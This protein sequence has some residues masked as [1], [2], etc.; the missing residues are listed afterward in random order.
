MQTRY[1]AAILAGLLLVGVLAFAAGRG[2]GHVAPRP[3]PVDPIPPRPDPGPS[4]P[5]VP[6]G[7]VV[8]ED[9]LKVDQSRG[10]FL[11]NKRVQA[12]FKATNLQH[13]VYSVGAVGPDGKPIGGRAGELIAA[14]KAKELPYLF[15]LDS[16]GAVIREQKLDLT[17]PDKFIDLFDPHAET[18][19]AMGCKNEPPLLS[20]T[21]F[22][23]AAAP[24][25]RLIPREQ[26]QPVDLEAY[27][28][29]VYD[30]DGRG[31]CNASAT[32]SALEFAREVGGM[33]YVHLSAGDLYSQINGGRDDGSTLE[34][35]LRAALTTGVAT[36]RTVPYVWNGRR[37]E[38]AAAK[39]ERQLYKA[40]E[41]YLCP[42]F[43]HVASAIQQGFIPIIGMKWHGNFKPD[44]DGWLPVRGSGGYGGHAI[45]VCGLDKRVI[46]GKEVWALKIRNSW[47]AAWGLGGNCY[48]PEPLLDGWIG[49]H[50]AVRSVVRTPDSFPA[51]K[52][53]RAVRLSLNPSELF[54]PDVAP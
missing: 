16:A 34:A 23:T 54:A 25:T 52:T 53:A 35:G 41:V 11:A 27:L 9:T 20:W 15:A 17:E 6:A 13:A 18:P 49:G 24:T 19:R 7:V 28:G 5:A 37:V 38:N 39:G 30:Q 47:S 12:F 46:G 2:C 45:A 48:V 29:P 43:D 31:Q 14:A 32:C 4:P 26:W 42:S 3:D 40:A 50:W 1:L 33:E 44:R 8:V 22:G 10:L 51:V 36:A 21:E